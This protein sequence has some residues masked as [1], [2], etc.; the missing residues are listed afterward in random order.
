[1]RFSC[2]HTLEQMKVWKKRA[3]Q[4]GK[5]FSAWLKDLMNQDCSEIWASGDFD[6]EEPE[7]DEPEP[8]PVPVM[9]QCRSCNLR[10]RVGAKMIVGCRECAKLQV[11]SNEP[12]APPS[13]QPCLGPV[14][15][16]VSE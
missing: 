12:E 14:D 8:E 6:L 4:Q 9:I 1:M 3:A 2:W 5:H 15:S 13:D 7:P 11:T 10:S 16:M